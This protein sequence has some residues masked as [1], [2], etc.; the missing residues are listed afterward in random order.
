MARR[1]GEGRVDGGEGGGIDVDVEVDD[2]D[3]DDDDAGRERV[4]VVKTKIDRGMRLKMEESIAACCLLVMVWGLGGVSSD[5]DQH[6]GRGRAG[7]ETEGKTRF[8]H[9]KHEGSECMVHNQS[10]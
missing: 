5:L 6:N 10:R 3:D 2:D 8:Y 9:K 4:R 7:A 1:R